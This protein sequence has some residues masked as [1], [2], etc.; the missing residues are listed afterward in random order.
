MPIGMVG[1]MPAPM[2]IPGII[3]PRS[4]VIMFIESS[5]PGSPGVPGK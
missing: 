3:I 5:Y 4:V 2:F 1:I